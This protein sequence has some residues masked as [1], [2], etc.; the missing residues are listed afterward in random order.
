MELVFF[1]GSCTNDHDWFWDATVST[2]FINQSRG[3]PIPQHIALSSWSKGSPMHHVTQHH[4]GVALNTGQLYYVCIS[5]LFSIPCSSPLYRRYYRRQTWRAGTLK[6]SLCNLTIT[7]EIRD[8]HQQPER[9]SRTTFTYNI[10]MGSSTRS[11]RFSTCYLLVSLERLNSSQEGTWA[12]K[13]HYYHLST[14]EAFLRN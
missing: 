10:R 8:Y 7:W 6:K 12:P 1:Q 2:S 11:T 14:T 13:F 4:I 5:V 3:V 9:R